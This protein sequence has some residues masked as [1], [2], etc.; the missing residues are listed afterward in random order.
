M[1]DGDGDDGV[2]HYAQPQQAQQHG[3]EVVHLRRFDDLRRYQ[4]LREH[5]LSVGAQLDYQA[6]YG[7]LD[8]VVALPG[9]G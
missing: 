6:V 3:I 5:R 9:F 8:E 4:M 2:G 7:T 1:P